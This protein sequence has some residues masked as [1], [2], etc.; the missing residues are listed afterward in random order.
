MSVP[1]AFIYFFND[2]EASQ[3]HQYCHDNFLEVTDLFQHEWNILI[4]FNYISFE[5]CRQH[6]NVNNYSI[7]DYLYI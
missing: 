7:R 6:C 2:I 5:Q 1:I 3:A 4:F